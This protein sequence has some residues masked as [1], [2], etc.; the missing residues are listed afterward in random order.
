MRGAYGA[1]FFSSMQTHKSEVVDSTSF[2]PPASH[3][4]E[5]VISHS[6]LFPYRYR[7]KKEGELT[8]EAVL[9]REKRLRSVIGE[10]R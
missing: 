9:K 4:K 6:A 10:D 1:F 5:W 3:T 7:R 2:T 8:S